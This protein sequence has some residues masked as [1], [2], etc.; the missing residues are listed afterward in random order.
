MISVGIDPSLRRTGLA[1]V[2]KGTVSTSLVKTEPVVG[3]D[4]VDDLT[5]Y[6]L[7][8]VVKFT[9]RGSLVVIEGMYVP[10]G[11]R[12]AGDVIERA[13]LLAH[14]ITQMRRRDCQVVRVWPKQRAKYATGDGN[15]DKKTVR[16]VMRERFPGVR[17]PDDNVADAV[18]LAAAGSR[19]LGQPIDGALSKTQQEAMA[20]VAWPQREER[21]A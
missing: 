4:A 7:G 14:I 12:T 17:I 2:E 15:A 19:W 20:A 8:C 16:T 9:P 11:E 10:K 13:G 3:V 18:A 6:I 1:L 21:R 5:L